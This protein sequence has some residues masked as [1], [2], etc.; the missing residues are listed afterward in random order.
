ML[1]Y[2]HCMQ[3]VVNR[4]IAKFIFAQR[5]T[6][7]HAVRSALF[8]VC[9]EN[10]KWLNWPIQRPF[11][12]A[13][14]DFVCFRDRGVCG[15]LTCHEL[16]CFIWF[17]FLFFSNFEWAFTHTHT[18]EPLRLPHPSIQMD[19]DLSCN[20]IRL[21]VY[22][23]QM[24][25]N[26]RLSADCEIN[27]CIYWRKTDQSE[28]GEQGR[29]WNSIISYRQCECVMYVTLVCECVCVCGWV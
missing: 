2:C 27:L 15:R 7:V 16:L 20:K 24:N 9:T 18:F 22:S 4:K 19:G 17:N 8:L 29:F 1:K 13:Q 12:V 3:T 28:N 11:D 23:L 26:T 25:W 14:F 10:K 5:R 21:L 6:I